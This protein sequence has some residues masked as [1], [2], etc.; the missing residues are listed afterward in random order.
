M[1][2]RWYKSFKQIYT[3]FILS[4]HSSKIHSFN[5]TAVYILHNEI[6]NLWKY[7]CLLHIRLCMVKI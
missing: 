6:I 4:F 5:L 7:N 1:H 3:N 2:L